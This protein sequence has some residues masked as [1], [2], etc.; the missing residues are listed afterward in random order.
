[1]VSS[2]SSK[3][4]CWS[5]YLHKTEK[6]VLDSVHPT[7]NVRE[8]HQA[9]VT[10]VCRAC[11][12]EITKNNRCSMGHKRSSWDFACTGQ[13]R[14]KASFRSLFP[15]HVTNFSLKGKRTWR[16]VSHRIVCISSH[17]LLRLNWP[18]ASPAPWQQQHGYGPRL[19]SK[20]WS[21]PDNTNNPKNFNRFR[22]N[23][24]TERENTKNNPTSSLLFT[25][26]PL[27]KRS[28]TNFRWPL[29]A[30][31]NNAVHPNCR[32]SSK[33]RIESFQCTIRKS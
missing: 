26:A 4:Q 33:V 31:Y 13:L 5:M 25:S 32:H 19:A 9:R 18:L 22:S 28:S 1:M 10:Q 16:V 27:S 12:G 15:C 6:T 8:S 20:V 2:M 29:S 14:V 30:A 3:M 11:R 24:A 21:H 17:C 7:L 23:K